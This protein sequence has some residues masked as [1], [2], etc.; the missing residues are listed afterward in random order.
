MGIAAYTIVLENKLGTQI[1]KLGQGGFKC[2]LP[3]FCKIGMK[4]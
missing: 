3:L 1:A 2:L 4:E